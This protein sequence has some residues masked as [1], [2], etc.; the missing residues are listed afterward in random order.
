MIR[1][2]HGTE[3]DAAHS[4]F[5]WSGLLYYCAREDANVQLLTLKGVGYRLVS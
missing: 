3:L 2:P 1:V 4:G 5:D